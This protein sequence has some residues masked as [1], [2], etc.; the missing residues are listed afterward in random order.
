MNNEPCSLGD[1]QVI[2]ETD[3]ALLVD[4]DGS[5]VWVPKSVVH[6]DS[7]VW[8]AENAVGDLVVKYWWAAKN[9]LA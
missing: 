1:A 8:S 3:K 4:L 6:D 5:E 7:E 2:R 9:G